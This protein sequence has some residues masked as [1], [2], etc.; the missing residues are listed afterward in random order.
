MLMAVAGAFTFGACNKTADDKAE[1]MED[2]AQDTAD[3]MKDAARD[4]DTTAVLQ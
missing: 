4:T 1:R 3:D 2:A